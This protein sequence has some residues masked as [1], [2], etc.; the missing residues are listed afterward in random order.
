M[1]VGLEIYNRLYKLQ[2]PVSVTT[3][4]QQTMLESVKQ[5]LLQL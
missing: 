4:K 1:K 5:L 2:L 3:I